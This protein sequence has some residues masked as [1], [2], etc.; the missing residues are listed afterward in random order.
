MNN[1]PET[2]P[3]T[4]IPKTIT[5]ADVEVSNTDL[6]TNYLKKNNIDEANHQKSSNKYV[7][8][9]DMYKIYNF[10]VGNNNEKL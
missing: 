2:S 7:Y 6:E 1:T 5:Y 4:E 9:T 3:K 8:E 10:I